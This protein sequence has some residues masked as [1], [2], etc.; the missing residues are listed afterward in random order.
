MILHVA[1]S[2]TIA[3]VNISDVL[4][5]TLDQTGNFTKFGHGLRTGIHSGQNT[6]FSEET[7]QGIDWARQKQDR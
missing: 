1:I 5:I 6:E 7:R 3:Q 2:F 4:E